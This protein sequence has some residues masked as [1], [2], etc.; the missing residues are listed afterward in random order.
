MDLD[1]CAD[2]VPRPVIIPS[3][4]PPFLFHTLLSA[5]AT[6]PLRDFDLDPRRHPL[7]ALSTACGA[8][9]NA[10]AYTLICGGPPRLVGNSDPSATNSPFT[11]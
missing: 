8:S 3:A 7:F 6:P 4:L 10:N 2:D 5:A 9:F 1:E 11:K